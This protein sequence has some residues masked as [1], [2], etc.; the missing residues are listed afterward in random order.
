MT[1]QKYR[2]LVSDIDGTL[3][4]NDNKLAE[5]TMKSIQ[6]FRQAGGRFTLATGRN[7]PH[8]IELIRK[9]E[10]DTPVILSDGAVL[11]DPVSDEK[12]VISNY[13][14]QQFDSI[15]QQCRDISDQIDFFTFSYDQRTKEYRVYGITDHP[16]I[17]QY[18]TDWH[19]RYAIVPSFEEVF[20]HVYMICIFA[21]INDSKVIPVFHE[22]CKKQ[23]ENFQIHLW[24]K[25]IAQI[26]PNTT[27]KG[28]A[29]ST[30]CEQLAITTDEVVAIGDQLND[31]SMA[32]T[33][34][35][36]AAME[37]GDPR[38]KES[39]HLV[40]PK[41]DELG[42]AHFIRNYLLKNRSREPFG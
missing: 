25:Q 30:L 6:Q 39:A 21:F 42:V 11:Y 1:H 28:V 23:E 38:V 37:N 26:F 8:T 19:Y 20:D 5:E 17:K 34:G 35:F 14:W 36:F 31:L 4:S 9:L 29:I 7:F 12:R 33:A 16:M 2:L 15:I 13:T 10:L 40:V 24:M 18:A 41:N 27:T 32:Q 22:W 3:L